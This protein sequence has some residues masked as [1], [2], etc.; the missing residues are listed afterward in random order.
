[1]QYPLRVRRFE[2]A[3]GTG[4]TGRTP[5]GD[6][7]IRELEALAACEGTLLGDRRATPPYGLAGG[8]AGS[9][10][11]DRIVGGDGCTCPLQGKSRF[12]LQSGDVLSIQ[13]PVR[14]VTVL[15]CC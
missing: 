14:V 9:R 5:G 10:A 4:G 1:M 3:R 13:T 11:A 6:G 15:C 8:V 2:R 12:K 7:I